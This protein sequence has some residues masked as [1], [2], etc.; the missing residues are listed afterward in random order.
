[1]KMYNLLIILIIVVFSNQQKY[2]NNSIHPLNPNECKI[3]LSEE[4]IKN[5]IKYCC[6]IEIDDNINCKGFTQEEY[7]EIPSNVIIADDNYFHYRVECFSIFIKL[8]IIYFILF[9][10]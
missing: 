3:K 2:C 8:N 9:L 4:E 1:M 7:E 5:G 10:F 6:Y